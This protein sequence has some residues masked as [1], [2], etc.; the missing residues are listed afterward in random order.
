SVAR[1]QGGD[2]SAYGPALAGDPAGVRGVRTARRASREGSES[3]DGAFDRDA[4]SLPRVFALG[5]AMDEARWRNERVGAA[6]GATGRGRVAGA[7]AARGRCLPAGPLLRGGPDGAGS[8]AIEFCGTHAGRDPAR[9]PHP[10]NVD[11]GGTGNGGKP[12]RTFAGDGV[13]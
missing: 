9:A 2:G 13:K 8:A 6:A 1:R 7:G 11:A 12:L 3:R 10:G 4:G 5:V